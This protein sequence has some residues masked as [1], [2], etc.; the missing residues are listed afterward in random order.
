MYSSPG[1]G[2]RRPSLPEGEHKRVHGNYVRDKRQDN[3]IRGAGG[4]DW[5]RPWLVFGVIFVLITVILLLG[6]I[7]SP[8]S[9][10]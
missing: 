1:Q 8:P 10:G 4:S 6:F 3:R 2:P 9:A 7:L 5:W